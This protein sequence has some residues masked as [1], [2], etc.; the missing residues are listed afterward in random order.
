MSVSDDLVVQKHRPLLSVV[1]PQCQRLMRLT[2]IAPD[3]KYD[4]VDV[5]TYQCECGNEAWQAV[6][7]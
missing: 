3:D 1:C 7:R 2:Q 6:E 5:R 4:H